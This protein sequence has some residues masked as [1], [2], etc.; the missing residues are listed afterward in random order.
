MAGILMGLLVSQNLFA[1][2]FRGPNFDRARSIVQATDEGFAVAGYT[3][4]FGAG[5]DD[6]LVLKLA[7][8]GSLSWA[9]TFGGTNEDRAQ[10]IIQTTDGGFAVAGRITSSST[11]SWDFVVLKLASD[12]SLSWARTFGGADIDSATAIVQTAD[13]GFAV[14]GVTHSFGAGFRDLLVLKLASD[15]S[16]SWARTFGEIY[17]DWAHYIIQTT[18]GGFAVA[19][20]TTSFGVGNYD[21]FILKLAPDGSLSWARTYGGTSN[22]YALSITQTMDGGFAVAGVTH[23]FG[24]GNDDLLVLK[25]ASDGSLS[26]ARTFG[27]GE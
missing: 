8:D 12:G 6:L 25:L 10:F 13:G 19:G 11:Y 9:I 3:Y 4:S 27:G 24:A 20:S 7:P 14:A 16:L 17:D 2:A 5:N 21:L 15:G 22:D 18:D 1:K 23:S 26:W